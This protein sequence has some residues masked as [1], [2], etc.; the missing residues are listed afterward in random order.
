MTSQLKQ[1]NTARTE[2]EL[3]PLLRDYFHK[4]NPT[5]PRG[6]VPLWY[7][8]EFSSAEHFEKWLD[9]NFRLF[10]SMTRTAEGIKLDVSL[11]LK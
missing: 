10:L 1:I 9:V 6:V 7:E 4:Q 5:L 8:M 11:Y 3:Q 2:Q